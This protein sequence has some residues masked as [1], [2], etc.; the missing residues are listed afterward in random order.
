MLEHL[1]RILAK[2]TETLTEFIDR[3]ARS[4]VWNTL[5]LLGAT[6]WDE[7]TYQATTTYDEFFILHQADQ[8]GKI[9]IFMQDPLDAYY[10]VD[11]ID[12]AA[13]ETVSRVYAVVGKA[14]NVKVTNGAVIQ[15]YRATY[16][17]LRKT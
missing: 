1:R 15:T 16:A 11:E 10:M 9:Q 14:V 8:A 2:A 13:N 12:Y 17:A 4:T 5:A 6:T 7:S 3:H